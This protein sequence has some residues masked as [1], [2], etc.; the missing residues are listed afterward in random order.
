MVP[1]DMSSVFK[2]VVKEM[3]PDRG[4]M[5]ESHIQDA[6]KFFDKESKS[7]SV[8]GPASQRGMPTY[9]KFMACVRETMRRLDE[10][11]K[12]E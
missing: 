6:I 12:K 8:P 3:W 4:D 9:K 10:E 11:R 2:G 7:F 1:V 5:Y